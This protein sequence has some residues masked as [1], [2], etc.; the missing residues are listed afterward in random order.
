M[1]FSEHRQTAIQL[2]ELGEPERLLTLL[3]KNNLNVRER[4]F[5]AEILRANIPKGSRGPEKSHAKPIK[6]ALIWF[7]RHEIDGDPKASVY[8]AIEKALCLAKDSGM[9]RKHLE[10]LKNPKTEGQMWTK[11]FAQHAIEKR[12]QAIEWGDH[13]LIQ[14]YRLQDLAPISRE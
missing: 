8:K 5:I 2:Y 11:L 10:Q 13:E 9:V 12:R 1:D 6:V 14:H 7:W 3:A 4:E